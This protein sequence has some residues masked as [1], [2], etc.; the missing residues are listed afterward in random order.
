[1]SAALIL[2]LMHRRVRSAEDLSMA[3]DLPVLAVLE[4][5]SRPGNWLNRLISMR[6][7]LSA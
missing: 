5:E 4:P 2:E 7:P 1:V 3:L 6:R